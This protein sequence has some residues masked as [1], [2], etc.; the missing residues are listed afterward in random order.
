MYIRVGNVEHNVYHVG[1]LVDG[2][3]ARMELLGALIVSHHS[4]P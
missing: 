2:L 1:L 3:D 4:L